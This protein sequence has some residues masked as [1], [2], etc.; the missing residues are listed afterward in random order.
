MHHST[1]KKTTN[2]SVQ[3]RWITGTGLLFETLATS[4]FADDG[5]EQSGKPW[6]A[7]ARM[8]RDEGESQQ[9]TDQL[10]ED[11]LNGGRFIAFS[12]WKLAEGTSVSDSY[13]LAFFVANLNESITH[14]VTMF[15]QQRPVNGIYLATMLEIGFVGH[16]EFGRDA[17]QPL[18]DLHGPWKRFAVRQRVNDNESAGALTPR[19]H[20][21]IFSFLSNDFLDFHFRQI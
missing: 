4:G 11:A 19:K 8:R 15:A 14:H 18:Q 3:R 6:D 12:R 9:L 7:D 16:E 1:R 13:C 17:G 2:K 20:V 21:S 5:H 10:L